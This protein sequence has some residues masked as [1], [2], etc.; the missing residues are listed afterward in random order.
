MI[1]GFSFLALAVGAYFIAPTWLAVLVGL[2]GFGLL[3]VR[4]SSPR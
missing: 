2:I 4:A 1:L 3:L